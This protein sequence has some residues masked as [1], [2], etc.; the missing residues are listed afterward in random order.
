MI[1]SPPFWPG[2][3]HLSGNGIDED[4]SSSTGT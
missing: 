4:C 1:A 2:P 3:L